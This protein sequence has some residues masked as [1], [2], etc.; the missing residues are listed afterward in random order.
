MPLYAF[1]LLVFPV[2]LCFDHPI[3]SFGGAVNIGLNQH[4]LELSAFYCIAICLFTHCLRRFPSRLHKDK[5]KELSRSPSPQYDHNGNIVKLNPMQRHSS[6][7][8]GDNLTLFYALFGLLAYL[9]ASNIFLHVGF[10]V[11]ERTLYLP[12]MAFCLLAGLGAEAVVKNTTQM[13]R[14]RLLYITF[15]LTTAVLALKTRQRV[16]VWQNEK[17]LYKSG[18]T[19]SPAKCE[20]CLFQKTLN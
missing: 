10:L 7:E 19:C 6:V 1:K 14:R 16:E 4:F 17:A 2:N 3:E 11:A 13:P 12:A 20:L 9:P 15:A 8:E 5:A 18:L